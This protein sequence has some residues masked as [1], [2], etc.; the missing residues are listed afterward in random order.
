M[1]GYYVRN[2]S[3]EDTLIKLAKLRDAYVVQGSK[4][5]KQVGTLVTD[6]QNYAKRL[7]AAAIRAKITARKAK[8]VSVLWER[9]ASG[10][11]AKSRKHKGKKMAAIKKPVI[12]GKDGH[13]RPPKNLKGST[14]PG[15]NCAGIAP[16][17]KKACLERLSKEKVLANKP[18]IV[19]KDGHGLPPK[20]LKANI[21]G[22]DCA[23]IAP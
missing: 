18:V 19:G 3:A 11:K 2:K 22:K 20:N 12:V 7:S 13:G 10:V 6:A 23:G 17:Y 14:R 8:K 16:Q 21:R 15:K 1:G 9:I 5:D 4:V